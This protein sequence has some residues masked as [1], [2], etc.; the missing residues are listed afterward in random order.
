M[1]GIHIYKIVTK[2]VLL[3]ILLLLVLLTPISSAVQN[4]IIESNRP[5]IITQEDTEN[6]FLCMKDGFKYIHLEGTPDEIGYLHGSL[7]ADY[8]QRS[9]D[10]YAHAT[11]NWY[12]LSWEQC[13]RQARTFW[14]YVPSDQRS[15]IEAIARGA[16]ENGVKRPQGSETVDWVDILTLNCMWDLWW[17]VS[18][19]GNPFWWLPFNNDPESDIIPTPTMPHH[20]SAFIATGNATRDGGFVIT[21]SLWMP[22]FLSPSHA[23]FMDLEPTTGNRILMEVNAG[24]IWSGTEWYIN[25]GGLVVAETTLGSGPYNWGKTPSFVRLR[26]AIQQADTIDEFKNIMLENSNGA[27]CGDYLIGDS[28]TN[29]VAV[30][31]LGGKTWTIARTNDGFLPSCNYPWDPVVA[32]E[33]GEPQGWDHGCYP[34]WVRWNQLKDEYYGDITVEHAKIFIGDHYDTTTDEWAPSRYTLCGHVENSSGY[35]HGSIDA[36]ATNQSMV[37]RMETWARFGHS[38]GSPFIVEDHKEKNPDY[39]F[40]D[41][42]D[43]IPQRW[44]TFGAFAK[45]NVLVKD[46]DGRTVEGANV[47]FKN[48]LDDTIYSAETDQTGTVVFP[49][50]PQSEYNVTAKNGEKEVKERIEISSDLSFELIL[51]EPDKKGFAIDDYTIWGLVTVLFILICIFIIYKKIK[52]K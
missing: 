52:K 36:K 47:T 34:R 12:G 18:P 24:L 30:L 42:V 9:L 35:P 37:S 33:M 23:V 32:E 48:C 40:P 10:G 27:Y 11:E 25:S 17:R 43:I 38:C 2:I 45:V 7:L 31:E 20:C 50:L 51:K 21:Q 29:E 22:Y 49:Y 6:Y 39:A 15:E 19:P 44:A 13:R 46:K 26:K 16:A 4:F 8:V 41:L 1:V 14:V 5:N 28:D 3:A